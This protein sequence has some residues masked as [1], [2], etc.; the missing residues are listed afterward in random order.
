M[1]TSSSRTLRA[2]GLIAGCVLVLFAVVSCGIVNRSGGSEP[3]DG[4]T[5]G[6]ALTLSG[7]T[8]VVID[9]NLQAQ[10][11]PGSSLPLD[12][13][14]KN[15]T[16]RDVVITHVDVDVTSVS[17]PR[18]TAELPCGVNDFAVSGASGEMN[19]PAKTSR[20]LS[21]AGWDQSAWPQLEM[22]NSTLNQD[23]CKGA[24][25]SLSYSAAATQ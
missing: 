1:T 8:R 10:L 7:G 24:Q 17:A 2:L 5:G 21:A 9:V 23:G 11:S 20:A 13:R 22:L 19:L 3:V 16:N 14:V 25:I 15:A 6:S 12:L 18:S 4:A